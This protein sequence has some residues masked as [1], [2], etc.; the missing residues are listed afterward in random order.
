MKARTSLPESA[1]LNL[2]PVPY[3]GAVCS[4]SEYPYTAENVVFPVTHHAVWTAVTFVSHCLGI[5]DGMVLAKTQCS[6][7]P[8]ESCLP[9]LGEELKWLYRFLLCLFWYFKP[10]IRDTV[11][12][13]DECEILTVRNNKFLALVWYNQRP[14]ADLS[15]GK[16]SWVPQWAVLEMAP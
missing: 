2:I 4:N 12:L 5:L 6:Y 13:W 16:E 10:L 8:S 3:P 7:L 1:T 9:W 15:Q 14:W 11:D